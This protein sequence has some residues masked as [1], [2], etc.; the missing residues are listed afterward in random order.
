MDILKELPE[1]SIALRQQDKTSSV[2]L[3]KEFLENGASIDVL[4]QVVDLLI[5]KKFVPPSNPLLCLC[6]DYHL[7]RYS[8]P[9]V[10][11][12]VEEVIFPLVFHLIDYHSSFSPH[13]EDK[14]RIFASI[15]QVSAIFFFF[16]YIFAKELSSIFCF[17]G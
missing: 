10:S 3:V 7:R 6:I 16:F 15:P 8:L 4:R 13:S 5:S 12:L 14:R 1:Y 2:N 17:Q 11:L 9:N